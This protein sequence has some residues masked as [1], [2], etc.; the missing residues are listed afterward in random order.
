MSY[1]SKSR[2]SCGVDLS[3][4]TATCKEG[5]AKFA[6]EMQVPHD[7]FKA[8]FNLP[9]SF[10]Q[11]AKVSLEDFR[12]VVEAASLRTR[13]ATPPWTSPASTSTSAGREELAASPAL[14]GAEHEGRREG[15]SWTE[16]INKS[17]FACM[18]ILLF[19]SSLSQLD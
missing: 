6:Y 19:I 10:G 16:P 7:V 9:S 11:M 2:R 18:E 1:L 14:T 13:S 4:T 17:C 15:C 3:L 8:I 5:R 12:T